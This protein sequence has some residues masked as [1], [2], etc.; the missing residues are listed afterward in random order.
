MK[1]FVF[2]IL[3]A[4]NVVSGMA[5]C[6]SWAVPG[7]RQYY[8]ENGLFCVHTNPTK[9]TDTGGFAQ[10]NVNK[11]GMDQSQRPHWSC[12]LGFVGSPERCY[13]SNNGKAVVTVDQI[14]RRKHGGFGDHILAFY[15]KDGI[16][17]NYSLAEIIGAPPEI[18]M[19]KLRM[20]IPTSVSGIMWDR[21]AI[22]FL[23]EIDGA[24]YFCM[25]LPIIEKWLSWD[26][27]TGKRVEISEKM[28][29]RWIEKARSKVLKFAENKFYPF[30]YLG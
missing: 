3:V 10:I 8:S 21:E 14:D 7:K 26:T 27:E 30:A 1:K 29:S 24:E 16:V 6:D 20:A 11:V 12:S 25:W 9:G 19:L 28:Q 5:F 18:D 23:D 17:K 15:N 2:L 4:F 22:E 13:I